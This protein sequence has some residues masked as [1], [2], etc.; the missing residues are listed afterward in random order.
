MKDIQEYTARY[1]DVYRAGFVV[2]TEPHEARF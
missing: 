2:K 1:G